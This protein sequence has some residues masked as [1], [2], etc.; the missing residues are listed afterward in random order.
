MNETNNTNIAVPVNTTHAVVKWYLII[1]IY[2]AHLLSFAMSMDSEVETVL[3]DEP[4]GSRLDRNI[5]YQEMI[6]VF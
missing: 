4:N 2:C 6:W 1:L 5:L 3:T